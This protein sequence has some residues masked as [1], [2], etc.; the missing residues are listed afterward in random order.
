MHEDESLETH[1]SN[2][3]TRIIRC[4]SPSLSSS[5]PCARQVIIRRRNRTVKRPNKPPR[6]RQRETRKKQRKTFFYEKELITKN[7]SS[8]HLSKQKHHHSSSEQSEHEQDKLKCLYDE[9]SSEDIH[10]N[11]KPLAL[12]DSRELYQYALDKYHRKSLSN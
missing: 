10:R 3:E 2:S 7:Q 11:R 8:L 12:T 1:S 6:R 4:Y 5:R 9:Y